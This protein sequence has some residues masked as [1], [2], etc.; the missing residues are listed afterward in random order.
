[1]CDNMIASTRSGK[2]ALFRFI[3]G[4]LCLAFVSDAGDTEI[5][6]RGE[7]VVVKRTRHH[8]RRKKSLAQ[9]QMHRPGRI[10]AADLGFAI[11]S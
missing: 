1:M 3:V 8:R 11:R 10:P 4:R 6:S 2:L 9:A 7:S 5:A